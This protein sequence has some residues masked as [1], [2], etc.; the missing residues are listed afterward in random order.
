MTKT[1]DKRG[2]GGNNNPTGKG[3]FQE[4]PQDRG[5]GFW[6]LQ[7]TP[8][9]KL[10]QMLKMPHADLQAV[11]LDEDA[12]LFE[13]KLAKCLADGDWKVIRE[14]IAEVYG[15]PKQTIEQTVIEKPLPLAD[16]SFDI[17]D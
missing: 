5:H 12:P 3:G 7:D 2:P 9:F 11:A 17:K 16:L 4:R 1:Q 13:R 10:E 8:R 15:T 6:K 14:M